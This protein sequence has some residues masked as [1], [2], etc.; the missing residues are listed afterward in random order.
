MYRKEIKV[1]DCTI[2]DGGLIHKWGFSDKFVKNVFHELSLSGIDY[3][4]IGYKASKNIIC[5]D[6]MGKWRFCDEEDIKPIV[7]ETR[8]KISAMV[9]IGRVDASD[10]KPKKDSVI[11]MIRI[12]SYVK[13]IDK[14]IDM[15]KMFHDKGYETTVN[16]MAVSN[17]RDQELDEALSQLAKSEAGTVY[18][19][20]SYGSL[21]CEQIEYL[22]KKYRTFLPDKTIGIHAHNNMQLAF[23]NTI[24]AIIHGADMLDATVYGIGRGAGNCPIE[25]LIGFLKNPKFRIKPIIRLIEQQFIHLRKEIEWGYMIPYALTGILDQHPRSAMKIRQTD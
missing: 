12:A 11:D 14:A 22:I 5:P 15:V 20:D 3:M 9:D 6:G 2:R 23:G 19:V 13:D 4:E 16:I 25:L 24:E 7:K 17:A 8:M 10:I 18:V 1:L 21:Y